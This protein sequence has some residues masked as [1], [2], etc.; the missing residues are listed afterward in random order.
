M[1]FNLNKSF[2]EDERLEPKPSGHLR[3]L[4]LRY[5]L[6]ILLKNKVFNE[7]AAVW[8][9]DRISTEMFR[10]QYPRYPNI[11]VIII[12]LLNFGITFWSG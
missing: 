3:G 1:L 2:Q 11:E 8:D 10:Q 5:Q 6:I 9:S 7:V 12:I 4:I